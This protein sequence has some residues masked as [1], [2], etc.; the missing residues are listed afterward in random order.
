MQ[1]MEEKT[2]FGRWFRR[3][4]AVLGRVTLPERTEKKKQAGAD[5]H[6]TLKNIDKNPSEAAVSASDG[7]LDTCIFGGTG[8]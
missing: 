8:A 1:M 4:S 6:S 3:Y 2:G 7:K 5:I